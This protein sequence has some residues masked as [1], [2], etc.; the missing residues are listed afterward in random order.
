MGTTAA[1]TRRATSWVTSAMLSEA[2]REEP[3][4]ATGAARSGRAP[5][6]SSGQAG[7]TYTSSTCSQSTPVSTSRRS[8]ASRTPTTS[9]AACRPTAWRWRLSTGTASSGSHRTSQSGMPWSRPTRSSGPTRRARTSTAGSPGSSPANLPRPPSTT[10]ARSTAPMC[11]VVWLSWSS[12]TAS[13]A[14]S[15]GGT[16]PTRAAARQAGAPRPFSRRWPRAWRGSPTRRPCTRR[17]GSARVS[18]RQ[19]SL[20]PMLCSP[21]ALLM[22]TS[23]CATGASPTRSASNSPARPL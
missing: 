11:S 14:S 15:T 20:R 1:F 4:G 2:A 7:T 17:S 10:A 5:T 8:S 23:P 12:A 18:R 9:T 21:T 6:P 19:A 13:W 16:A 3:S 22:P